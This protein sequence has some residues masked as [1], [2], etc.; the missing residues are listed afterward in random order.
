MPEPPGAAFLPRDGAEPF[1]PKS[2]S[3]PRTPPKKEKSQIEKFAEC[4]A[5]SP[6]RPPGAQLRTSNGG[7]DR[8]DPLLQAKDGLQQLNQPLQGRLHPTF[9]PAHLLIQAV[10]PSL[11]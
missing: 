2:A 4:P 7:G 9:Q 6:S 1:W 11:R 3:G 8:R 5:A 10:Q